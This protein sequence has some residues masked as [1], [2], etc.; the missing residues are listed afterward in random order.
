[1]ALMLPESI[2]T[3]VQWTRTAVL[4][5]AIIIVAFSLSIYSSHTIPVFSLFSEQQS[6]ERDSTFLLEM[7]Q[8]RRLIST[9]VAAQASIFCPLFLLLSSNNQSQHLKHTSS[10]NNSRSFLAD[11]ICSHILMPS[12][13]ALSWVF[14]IMFDR[15]TM[16]VL[17][18]QLL[19]QTP[20]SSW[21]WGPLQDMCLLDRSD[22]GN[23]WP[24]MVVNTMHGCK[25]LIVCVL[26][27]EIELVIAGVI[28]ARFC[29]PQI[30]LPTDDA[31]EKGQK[32]CV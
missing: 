11:L 14:C 22:G 18:S 23:Y 30:Q 25:Y 20:Q 5:M 21:G 10:N 12:G 2:Y 9:M 28:Y 24:C 6:F 31:E 17:S 26:L 1:M 13:L 3:S 29:R 27:L 19:K 7:V 4:V 16:A 32:N 8:D 15:K